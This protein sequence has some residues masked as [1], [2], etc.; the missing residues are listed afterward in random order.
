MAFPV[1]PTNG[2][3]T[4]VNNVAYQFSNVGNTWTRILSTA[5]VITANTIAVNGALTVGTTISAIG[6]ITGNYYF[7]NGSQLTGVAAASAGFPISAGNSNIAA[8]ANSNIAVTVGGTANVAVFAITGEYVTG[9]VSASGNITG[10][11]IL[12]DG[13]VSAAGNL[14]GL[15]AQFANTIIGPL[16]VSTDGG[17]IANTFISATGNVF[18]DY[19]I[20]N[21]RLLTGISSTS[22]ANGNSSVNIPATGGNIEISVNGAA[23]TAIVSLGSFTLNGAFAG[24]KTLDATVVVQE[25]VNAMLLGPVSLAANATIFVPT[26]STLYIYSP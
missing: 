7:G 13:I 8:A 4:V 24:P 21:G 11:N 22:I 9:V 1:S 20:G 5:N 10:G 19:Y 23:N 15:V 6:N 14:Y 16:G 25:A 17:L 18:G 26:T 3:I 2:Q 12:T